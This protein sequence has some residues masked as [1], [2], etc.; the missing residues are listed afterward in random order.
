MRIVK[1]AGLDGK[2]KKRRSRK[3]G[4]TSAPG[5]RAWSTWS[6]RRAMVL[7]RD[8]HEIVVALGRGASGAPF[9]RLLLAG[10]LGF[11]WAK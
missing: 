6:R 7:P 4:T 11:G 2:A 8:E 10:G 3:R 5:F 9:Q 1:V